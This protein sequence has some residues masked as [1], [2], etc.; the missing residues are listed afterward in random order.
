MGNCARTQKSSDLISVL[1]MWLDARMISP[2]VHELNRMLL[3]FQASLV[4]QTV[5]N[6]PAIWKTQVQSVGWKMW[7]REWLPTPV[8][9][10]GE[11]NGQRLQSLGSQRF[12][13]AD[14]IWN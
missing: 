12:Y 6:L 8:F 5:E 14:K 4:A 11:F 9:L 13:T 3:I 1:R 10:L 7:R 2:F